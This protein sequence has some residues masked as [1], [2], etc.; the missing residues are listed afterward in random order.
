MNTR[1]FITLSTLCLSALTVNARQ[2]SEAELLS[3]TQGQQVLVRDS[4]TAVI[5]LKEGGF[6]V[7][8]TDDRFPEGEMLLGYSTTSQYHANPAFCWW[9]S[10]VEQRGR[11]LMRQQRPRPTVIAPYGDYESS[12]DALCTARWGQESPY[13]DECPNGTTSTSGWGYGGGDGRCVT[14][15][16]ATAMAQVL[17]YHQAPAQGT[18]GQGSVSV[19]QSDGS[20]LTCTV[21]YDEATYDFANMIDEYRYG[22]YTD[23]EAAAV[24]HLMY[25]CGV[26]AKMEYATD[27][28]GAWMEDC[29]DGLQRYFGFEDA[30]LLDRDQYTEA[31]WMEIVYDEI[32]AGRPIIYAG[33]DMTYRAGHC[34]VLDGYDERGYVHINWGW[35]GSD[36]G[37]FD[38]ALLNVDGYHFSSYQQMVIGIEGDGHRASQWA[39][40]LQ[41]T[42]PGEVALHYAD[43]SLDTLQTLSRL[44]VQGPIDKADIAA[45]RALA[46]LDVLRQLDLR[47]AVLTD[48][49]MP[50]SALALATRLRKVVLPSNVR[51]LGKRA[52]AGCTGL[53]ELR[54]PTR[55]LPTLGTGS[56]NDVHFDRCKLY[57]PAGTKERYCR[58]AQW[59]QFQTSDFDNIVEFG[60]CVTPRNC[61]REQGQPNPQFGFTV[62]GNPVSGQ[63][64]LWCDATEESPVGRYAIHIAPGTITDPDADFVEGF[65]IIVEATEAIEQVRTDASAAATRRYNLLGQPVTDPSGITIS[66]SG[67][68]I[69]R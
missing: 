25:H 19:K 7:V 67:I 10:L 11:E 12:V 50:D 48:S 27:G 66:P 24:A 59:K 1:L 6:K 15:C 16:V 42:E 45:L 9:L 47:D 36:D 63:P 30:R 61:V 13:W 49:V 28:S 64:E 29:I 62:Y 68:R 56:M 5:G 17:Y 20:Y 54:V 43:L 21:D 8:L 4:A 38:I 55:N 65:M 26:A 53:T 35:E 51:K 31:A 39:D 34:F 52:L 40:T 58:A 41:T 22:Q 44:T 60:T 69:Q 37:Y 14:G 33:D 18:G 57:V 23:E 3:V 2:R 46:R 32:N